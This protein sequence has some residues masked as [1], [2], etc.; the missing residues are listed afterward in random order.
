MTR[1]D[2]PSAAQMYERFFGPSIFTPWTSVLLEHAAPRPG[3]QVL[4]LACG[5]GIVARHVAPLV[6]AQGKIT[7][8]D[9][10]PDM[11]EVARECCSAE[12]APLEWTEGDAVS[13][14]LPDEAFDLAICQQGFQFFPDRAAAAG[15]MCRVLRDG[16]RAVV[17][18]WKELEHH[19]VYK[20]VMEAE[21]DYLGEDIDEVA[22]P[23][24]FGGADALHGLFSEAG[25]ERVEMIEESVE[26]RFSQP[27]R[28]VHLTIVAAAAVLPDF[29]KDD[30]AQLV[31][32]VTAQTK[33]V[34][35]Q[36]RSGDTISFPM[37]AHIAIAHA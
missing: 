28:F 14:P 26:V 35:A 20:A 27:E 12:D 23:F 1:E 36:H 24:K 2:K 18:V 37:P 19:P 10:S 13:L 29:G 30:R 32:A 3:E 33:D 7:G 4:D 22:R 25:F 34:L 21:A 15:E 5:T 8:V 17:S 31:E 11:L 9:I 6:G 16:G